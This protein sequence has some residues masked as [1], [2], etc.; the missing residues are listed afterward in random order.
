M[1]IYVA[2]RYDE[3]TRLWSWRHTRVYVYDVNIQCSIIILR[4]SSMSE[5]NGTS[6]LVISSFRTNR[7]FCSCHSTD[8][9]FSWSCLLSATDSKFIFAWAEGLIILYIVLQPRNI[10]IIEA[11]QN[12]FLYRSMGTHFPSFSSP[13]TRMAELTYAII[14]AYFQSDGP[15]VRSDTV[16]IYI[17]TLYIHLHI[18]INICIYIYMTR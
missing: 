9:V 18:C 5:I 16:C 2:D 1:F 17:S 4:I 14:L 15:G 10:V 11:N 13:H 8:G 7:L 6:N 3:G 12:A